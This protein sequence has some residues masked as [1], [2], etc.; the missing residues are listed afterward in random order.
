MNIEVR[1][2]EIDWNSIKYEYVYCNEPYMIFIRE[3]ANVFID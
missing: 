2:N 1:F 3:E